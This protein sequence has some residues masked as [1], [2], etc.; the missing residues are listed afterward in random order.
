MPSL[1]TVILPWIPAVSY[2]DLKASP[3]FEAMYQ[4]IKKGI[5]PKLSTALMKA[6][7]LIFTTKKASYLS[8]LPLIMV[9]FLSLSFS[10][11]TASILNP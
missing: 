6:T 10:S 7:P 8:T 11:L 2:R 1:Q 9:R 3:G 5:T 4:A